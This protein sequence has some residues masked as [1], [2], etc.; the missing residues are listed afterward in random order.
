M[1]TEICQDLR[2][3]F[4]RDQPKW[5]GDFEITGGELQLLEGMSLLAG[6][7]YRIIGSALNDGVYCWGDGSELSDEAFTGAV[8]AMAVPKAVITLADDIKN[9]QD[10]NQAVL[11]SPYASESFGGYSY[12]KM[13]S[14]SGAGSIT[15]RDAFASRL[16]KWR[17]IL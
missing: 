4:D 14:K 12:S 8:W 7:Y 17:K 10:E 15:W 16:N 11:N 3:W 13:T 9:W 6:Q 2:N 1:L 5:Y